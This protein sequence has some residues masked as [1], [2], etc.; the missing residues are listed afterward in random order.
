MEGHCF[1][2]LQ[3]GGDLVMT[4]G[5]FSTDRQK[6][7]ITRIPDYVSF[8]FETRSISESMLKKVEAILYAECAEIEKKRQVRF[9]IDSASITNPAAMDHQITDRI[10]AA[11]TAEGIQP[12]VMPSGAGHDASVF[13][14][15]SIKTGM[16]FVRNYNGSHRPNEHLELDDFLKGVAV[17]KHFVME[18]DE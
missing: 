6:D 8:S 3:S 10:M 11:I 13:A 2:F 12:V 5:K 9:E 14:D 18:Y 15:S 16:I 1:D 17:L 7:A 4:S